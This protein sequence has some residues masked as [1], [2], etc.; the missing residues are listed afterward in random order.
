MALCAGFRHKNDELASELREIISTL[1]DDFGDSQ[2][3]LIDSVSC[4][5][6]IATELTKIEN[7]ESKTK[8]KNDLQAKVIQTHIDVLIELSDSAP[9]F[10]SSGSKVEYALQ[11]ANSIIL[12]HAEF[13]PNDHREDAHHF[14][15][16]W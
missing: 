10:V 6:N 2:L 16:T 7:I 14:T 5:E 3:S 11:V 9:D 12:I 8:T 13:R 4:I 15:N 1:R